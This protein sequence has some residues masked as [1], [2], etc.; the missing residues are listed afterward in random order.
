M[1]ESTR[2]LTGLRVLVAE[3]E[4]L[5]LMLLEDALEE[6]GCELVGAHATLSDAMQAATRDDYDVA[7][8]DFNLRG[9]RA[10]SLATL[11]V[12]KGRP[13]AIVSGAPNDVVG[14]GERTVIAKPFKVE[15]IGT[16]LRLLT[17]SSGKSR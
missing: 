3:D 4:P 13:F 14:L 6:L 9:E 16:G 2:D 17:D 15:D 1:I 7:M 12:E 8:M 5:I 11:F 10:T